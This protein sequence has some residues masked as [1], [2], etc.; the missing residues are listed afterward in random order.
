MMTPQKKEDNGE[1]AEGKGDNLEEEHKAEGDDREEVD[2][3]EEGHDTEGMTRKKRVAVQ[4]KGTRQKGMTHKKKKGM[5]HK[6]R[7]GQ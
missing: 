1:D 4:K 6:K 2:N 7:R 5:M 3:S